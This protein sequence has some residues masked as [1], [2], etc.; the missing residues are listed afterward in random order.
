MYSQ[1]F[2]EILIWT[3]HVYRSQEMINF[4]NIQSVGTF[5]WRIAQWYYQQFIIW[6]Q[7]S[8]SLHNR[9]FLSL[10]YD[11]HRNILQFN[12][13]CGRYQDD[14]STFKCMLSFFRTSLFRKDVLRYS[15]VCPSVCLGFPTYNFISLSHIKLKLHL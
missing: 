1:C 5:I 6:W 7:S 12:F 10:S 14:D 4:N 8:L 13:I 2:Y 9:I 11:N 3:F 15:N